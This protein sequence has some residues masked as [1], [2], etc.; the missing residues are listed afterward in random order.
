MRVFE[1]LDYRIF[2]KAWL[3][4][5]HQNGRG[6]VTKIAKA[7]NIHNTLF[8]LIL[9]GERDLTLEHGFALTRFLELNEAE[10]DYFMLLVQYSR[11]GNHEYKKD[12]KLKIE[13]ARSEALNL[14]NQF[15]HEKKLDTEQQMTF[16]SS[17]LYSAIRL[18]CSTH[19]NGRSIEEI[20]MRF[21]LKRIP[22]VKIID[23][24]TEND[25]LKK[26][27]EKFI[28]GTQR[29]YLERTS[30]LLSKHHSNWR[31]RAL[32]CFDGLTEEEIMF[33]SPMSLSK[34]D[35]EQIRNLLSELIKK[36]SEVVKESS[37][38]E[39]ACLNI[40]FFWIQ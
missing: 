27:K 7:I 19:E 39:V 9:S 12:L 25:L 8:S 6:Y 4:S 16:Y 5:R 35:F 40:D 37:A 36:S 10:A 15:V 1:Y 23:W 33:S 26:E 38:E 32:H 31:L 22:V 20:M 30:P 28:L 2:L 21:N 34:K 17:W 24:L 11:A 18:Y 13:K 3:K 29:T 14:S